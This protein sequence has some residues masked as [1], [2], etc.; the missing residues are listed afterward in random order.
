MSYLLSWRDVLPPP[1]VSLACDVRSYATI[2]SNDDLRSTSCNVQSGLGVQ[3]CPK[4]T[5]KRT[6]LLLGQQCHIPSRHRGAYCR[7]AMIKF[8]R[9]MEM[10]IRL[11]SGGATQPWTM[12]TGPFLDNQGKQLH[13]G[14]QYALRRV[15]FRCCKRKLTNASCVDASER[16]YVH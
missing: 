5:E 16:G 6:V 8:G 13:V 7:G 10:I 9:R 15:S 2:L 12:R 1:A 4:G 14:I 11:A 3:T